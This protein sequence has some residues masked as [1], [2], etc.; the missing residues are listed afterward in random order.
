MVR[1]KVEKCFKFGETKN[2]I[3][4]DTLMPARVVS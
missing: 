3:C 1:D 4:C 2:V